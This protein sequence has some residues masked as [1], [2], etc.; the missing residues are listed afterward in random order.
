MV[1]METVMMPLVEVFALLQRHLHRR[2]REER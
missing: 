1:R 2:A